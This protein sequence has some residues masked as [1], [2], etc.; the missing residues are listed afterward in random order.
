MKKDTL[1]QIILGTIGGLIASIGM[2]MCLVEEWGM[3]K[4]GIVVGVI[5]LIILLCIYPIYRKNNPVERKGLNKG[6]VATI[7]FGVIG[8]L[9]MGTGMSLC[10]V[11]NQ[12]AT[13]MII[14][15]VVG[16]VG[17]LICVLNYPIYA[18]LKGNK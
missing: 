5:G 1:I 9:I 18:Y 3:L 10:L 13:K 12:E 2:C 7:V 8:S 17:L 14:G 16:V 4:P 11:E 6:L 15:L